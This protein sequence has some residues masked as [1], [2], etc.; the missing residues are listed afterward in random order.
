MTFSQ[1]ILVIFSEQYFWVF[2]R[3]LTLNNFDYIIY[4]ET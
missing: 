4:T 2:A 1:F 3:P